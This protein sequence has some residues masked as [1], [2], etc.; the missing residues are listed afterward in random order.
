MTKKRFSLRSWFA[1]EVNDTVAVTVLA[2][3]ISIVLSAFE[4]GGVT[5]TIRSSSPYG[6]LPVHLAPGLGSSVSV[7][8]SV[9]RQ[10]TPTYHY[11]PRRLGRSSAASSARSSVRRVLPGIHTVTPDID[12]L[13][14]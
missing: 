6:N 12:Y 13:F 9:S 11:V 8:G 10:S 1:A 3:A 4:I 5:A 7:S 2:V 14:H